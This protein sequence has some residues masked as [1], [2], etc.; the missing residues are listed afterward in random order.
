MMLQLQTALARAQLR[1][2]EP[3]CEVTEATLRV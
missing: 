1:Y 3:V 2:L